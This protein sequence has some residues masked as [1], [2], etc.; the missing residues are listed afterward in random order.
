LGIP[1]D[2]AHTAASAVWLGGL[3]VLIFLVTPRIDSEKILGVFVKFGDVAKFAV[4]T[5]IVTGVIQTLRLHGGITTL[6]TSS[7]GRILL[8]KLVVVALMLKVGDINRRRLIRYASFQGVAIDRKRALLVRASYT[9]TTIGAV[10]V[11]LTA[12]LVTSSFN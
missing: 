1:I 8:L 12:V 6:F 7:H 11:A 5:I 2:I 4:I 10:V 9:E 3:I